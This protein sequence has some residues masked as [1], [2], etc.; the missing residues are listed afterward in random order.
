MSFFTIPLNTLK[1]Q[2]SHELLRRRAIH[3]AREIRNAASGQLRI[4]NET[5]R[6]SGAQKSSKEVDNLLN[7]VDTL[8]E[9]LEEMTL[10]LQVDLEGLGR[11]NGMAESRRSELDQLAR[12]VWHRIDKLQNPSDCSKAKFLMVGLTRPCAFG[13]NVHHLAYCFQMAYVSGRT[14]VFDNVK[15]AYDSWWK[16]NFLPLSKTCNQLNITDS[17]NIP[18]FDGTNETSTIRVTLCDY[19][20]SM[21]NS[22]KSLPPA[23]P[24]DLASNLERLHEVPF[25]WY[26]GH[27]T[28]YL[29]R[30]TL[31]FEQLLNSTLEAYKL[32]GVNR[33]P[34]VG[35]H[36]RRT[37]KINNEAAFYPLHEYIT[38]VERRFQFWQSQRQLLWKTDVSLLLTNYT[39]RCIPFVCVS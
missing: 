11:V 24:R 17:E 10:H 2:S 14:L 37:D 39:I 30:P 13:C 33:N 4:I 9:W 12:R 8:N 6:Q 35:V 26:I 1:V 21:S 29:M 20:G 32:V 25:I 27:L 19:I 7:K 23:I 34:V 22:V 38:H 36:V 28:A 3:F 5:L 15:T 18:L 31:A 16:A